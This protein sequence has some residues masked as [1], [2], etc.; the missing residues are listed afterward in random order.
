MPQQTGMQPTRAINFSITVKAGADAVYKAL[1]DAQELVKW[2]PSSATSEP[3]TG[4]RFSYRWEFQTPE[5]NCFQEGNYLELTPGKRVRYPWDVTNMPSAARYPRKPRPTTVEMTLTPKGPETQVSL[6]H[7]GW[8]FGAEWDALLQDHTMG[9]GF[10]LGN[11]KTTL[12]EGKD[13]RAARMGMKL[14]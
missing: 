12:E 14:P 13:Q 5:K 2:F 9:W 10:F 4:G 3:Q 8:G 11:L 6:Y 1:T 7:S